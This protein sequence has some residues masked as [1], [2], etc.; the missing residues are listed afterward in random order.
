[1]KGRLY[2]LTWKEGVAYS[3]DEATLAPRDSIR[4]AGEGWGLATDGDSLDHERRIRFPAH[5]SRRRPFKTERVVHVRYNGA[6]L[7]QINELEY[8]NGEVL[9]NVYESNWVMR[10]DPATGLVR[11]AIDFADCTRSARRRPKS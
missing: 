5:C 8:A 2:Q 3:Y 10:I 7:Y 6:P 4:Y 9:A 11:Q 1:M